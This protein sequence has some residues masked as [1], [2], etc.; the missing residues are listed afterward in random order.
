MTFSSRTSGALTS[1]ALVFSGR[2]RLISVH[3]ANS[4]GS[5]ASTIN[6]YDN[7]A[8]SGTIV[9][10]LIIPATDCRE[11]D[12]HGVICDT[13]LYTDISGGTASVTVEFA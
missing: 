2:V 11:Y 1:S 7:T 13:G 8:G 10:K 5:T 4:H 12:M 3:V 9:A 6:I